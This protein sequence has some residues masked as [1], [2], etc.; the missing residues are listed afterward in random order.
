MGSTLTRIYYCISVQTCFL[1]HNLSALADRWWAISVVL[2][3]RTRIIISV[4]TI[5]PIGFTVHIQTFGFECT[6]DITRVHWTY[7]RSQAHRDEHSEMFKSARRDFD[8]IAP[9][10]YIELNRPLRR[11]GFIICSQWPPAA[12]RHPLKVNTVLKYW[13]EHEYK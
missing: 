7:S 9:R 5:V 11:C 4:D 6:F 3:E 8:R 10:L 12:E 1:F 13:L 2:V